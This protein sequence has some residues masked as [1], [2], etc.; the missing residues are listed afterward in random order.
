M[1]VS[2]GHANNEWENPIDLTMRGFDPGQES[3]R[4]LPMANFYF[5]EKMEISIGSA[6]RSLKN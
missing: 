1:N 2:F 4:Y 6:Q 5:L 3:S